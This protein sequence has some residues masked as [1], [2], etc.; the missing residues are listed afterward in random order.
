MLRTFL[1]RAG[2]AVLVIA[3][4]FLAGSPAAGHGP[5]SSSHAD[6]CVCATVDQGTGW[7]SACEVGFVGSVKVPSADLFEMIDPHGHELNPAGISCETCVNALETGSFCKP[8]GIG[9]VDGR[10]Y[11][12]RLAYLIANAE[13]GNSP[14]LESEFERLQMALERLADCELCGVA[15][16]VDGRCPKCRIHYRDGKKDKT[17]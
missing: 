5:N 9:Y 3:C 4:S 1:N 11:V 15:S 8:C 17:R 2:L 12:S 13:P 6:V 16:Y 10:A 14:A 7:C